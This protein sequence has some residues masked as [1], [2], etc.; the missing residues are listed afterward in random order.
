MNIDSAKTHDRDIAALFDYWENMRQGTNIPYRSVIDPRGIEPLLQNAF[1]AEKIAPGLARMRIAGNHL[2]DLLGMEVRGM[3][4]SAFI[5]PEQR[6]SFAELLNSVFTQP[7]TLQLEL[8]S[9]TKAG[10]P[11]LSSTMVV[12]PLRS[13]MGAISRALGCLITHGQIGRPP[14][15][16][17]I[18]SHQLT[19]LDIRPDTT[20]ISPGMADAARDFTH[21]GASHKSER[22]YLRLIKD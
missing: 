11:A 2:T 19:R 10:K 1:V 22:P 21:D 5:A 3:P 18:V 4:I 14:R 7:A 8:H 20:G 17:S 12:L 15:R 6:D 16:F 9:E 13:E